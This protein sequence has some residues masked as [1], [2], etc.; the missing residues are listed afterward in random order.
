M[1]SSH[2]SSEQGEDHLGVTLSNILR[3]SVD[4]GT[5]LT[6]G[7][8]G[9]LGVVD[10]V[11]LRASD[12]EVGVVDGTRTDV[13]DDLSNGARVADLLVLPARDLVGQDAVGPGDD[14]SVSDG[15][16]S[17]GE[18]GKDGESVGAHGLPD[19]GESGSL[20]SVVDILSLDTN[21]RELEL[22]SDGDS[23]VAVLD[24]LHVA[25][26]GL[27]GGMVD[28]FPVD[29]TRL[30]LI[31][32]LQKNKTIT[33]VLVQMVDEGVDTEGVHP[34]TVGLLLTGLL[35][36]LLNDL[37]DGLERRVVVEQVSDE[38]QV[39]LSITI[40][41]IGGTDE[42]A[43]I[44]LVGLLKHLLGTAVLIRLSHSISVDSGVLGSD[45][46]Q[47]DGVG[48]RISDISSKVLDATVRSSLTQVVVDPTQEKLISGKLEKILD[49][50]SGLQKAVQLGMR[51]QV[52]LGKETNLDD[53][54][55]QTKDQ[56]VGSLHQVDRR[57]VD[58]VATNGTRRVQNQSL[59]LSDAE[60]VQLGLVDGALVDGTR[61]GIVDQLA[62]V[63]KR[64]SFATVK[65]ERKGAEENEWGWR[66]VTSKKF[67]R[68][69]L[70]QDLHISAQKGKE[71]V[72]NLIEKVKRI[73]LKTYHMRIP[74]WTDLKRESSLG[75]RGNKCSVNG[76]KMQ[77]IC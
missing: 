66:A 58:D 14:L 71:S 38:S 33:Q 69:F 4:G 26:D 60:S 74:S 2:E 34:V 11:L 17:S 42:L 29:D 32:K 39:E 27:P 23:V 56:M 1:S 67:F 55:H 76:I 72:D 21:E 31:Q 9:V 53:L 22:R 68:Q 75:L 51:L 15:L 49:G 54:P 63:P 59:V 5:D 28:L 44:D 24:L 40:D 6:S 18:L 8:D 45:L 47:Q 46:L 30:D 13:V 20:G 41:D 12:D 61:D 73:K 57:N 35:N 62:R 52:D 64:P 7:R 36:D 65:A 37:L 48:L 25:S 10:V 16:T 77:R 43:A 3:E 50:L 70:F 19:D